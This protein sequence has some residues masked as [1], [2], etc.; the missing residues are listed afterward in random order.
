[1]MRSTLDRQS[2]VIER[3]KAENKITG[4][5]YVPANKGAFR[6]PE[7]SRLLAEIEATARAQG[8]E[9]AFK[10]NY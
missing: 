1:M 3:F 5:D 6:S 10:A 2:A 9:P 7:K 4:N 8:R